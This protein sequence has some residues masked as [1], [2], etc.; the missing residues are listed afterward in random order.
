MKNHLA[1]IVRTSFSRWINAKAL[2]NQPLRTLGSG[3]PAALTMR[4]VSNVK[5][6][7]IELFCTCSDFHGLLIVLVDQCIAWRNICWRWI[8]TISFGMI[9]S[10]DNLFSINQ[11]RLWWPISKSSWR[12][13][14]LRGCRIQTQID[15]ESSDESIVSI[16]VWSFVSICGQHLSIFCGWNPFLLGIASS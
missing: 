2:I 14:I 5:L 8:W 7:H 13:W 10:L 16:N 15:P 4:T 9:W 1:R 6:S 3:V 11:L 12:I